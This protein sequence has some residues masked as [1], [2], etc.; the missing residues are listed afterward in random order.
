MKKIIVLV[1]CLVGC[2]VMSVQAFADSGSI[3]QNCP[4]CGKQIAPYSHIE[5]GEVCPYC[6]SIIYYC[7]KC[8]TSLDDDEK[9]CYECRIQER[10]T[11]TGV[12]IASGICITA[13]VVWVATSYPGRKEEFLNETEG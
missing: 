11:K 6:R 2:L 10:K 3:S 8:G 9:E 4:Y 5:Y 13:I 7:Q 1:V 12:V